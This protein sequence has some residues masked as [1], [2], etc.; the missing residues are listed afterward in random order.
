MPKIASWDAKWGA[1]GS[2]EGAGAERS[3]EFR[4][5]KSVFPNDLDEE[6]TER[7]QRTAIEAFT[8]LRLRDYARIDLRVSHDGEIHV[9]EVNPNCYLERNA[10]FA[11]AAQQDGIEY[12]ALI[13][14][15]VELALARYAR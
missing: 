5:T 4:G 15:I 6:L 1:D 2:G 7:L 9:I 14:R 8:A 10:E 12:D 13:G 3:A 11:R